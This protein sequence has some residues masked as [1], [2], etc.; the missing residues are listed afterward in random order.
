MSSLETAKDDCE[1]KRIFIYKVLFLY[2]KF[3][4]TKLLDFWEPYAEK[5]LTILKKYKNCKK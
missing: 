2:I 3:D 4:L 5:S 1:K